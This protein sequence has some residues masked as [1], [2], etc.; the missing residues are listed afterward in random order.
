MDVG[1]EISQASA[2][3]LYDSHVMPKSTHTSPEYLASILGL[4]LLSP[5]LNRLTSLA[6][7]SILFASIKQ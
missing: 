4:P 5:N 1:V 7:T 2:Y 6:R 3:T